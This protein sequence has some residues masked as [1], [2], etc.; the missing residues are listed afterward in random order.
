MASIVLTGQL[1][2]MCNDADFEPASFITYNKFI[3]ALPDSEKLIHYTDSYS[4][5]IYGLS[6][7]FLQDKVSDYFNS[8]FDASNEHKGYHTKE[9]E[10][11]GAQYK[12]KYYQLILLEAYHHIVDTTLHM[13]V[14]APINHYKLGYV[15]EDTM[16]DLYTHAT[17]NVLNIKNQLGIIIT[18]VK[19][20]IM[21]I[22][23]LACTVITF[24]ITAENVHTISACL[25]CI[26]IKFKELPDAKVTVS[27]VDLTNEIECKMV[28]VTSE[29]SSSINAT[30]RDEILKMIEQEQQLTD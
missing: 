25:K 3:E 19:V 29:E 26:D 8:V 18:E 9:V 28:D 12:N 1:L 23:N 6:E 5:Y 21:S 16:K 11:A 17:L 13:K 10:L 14:V 22:V 30:A 15:D 20:H 24:N 4:N 2:N 7:M 27:E